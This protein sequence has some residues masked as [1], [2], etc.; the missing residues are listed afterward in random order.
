MSKRQEILEYLK[1]KKEELTAEYNLSKIGL[2]G[3]Y[4]LGNYQTS[5]GI[6]IVVEF[7]S[8]T[9]DLYE[10]KSQIRKIMSSKLGS[11]VDVFREKYIKE[12]MNRDIFNSTIFV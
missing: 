2:F 7:E 12:Y 11:K 3:S 9:P 5:S 10:K 1:Q 4:A 8:D 6:D